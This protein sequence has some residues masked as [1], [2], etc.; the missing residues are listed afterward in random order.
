[1]SRSIIAVATD[2]TALYYFWFLCGGIWIIGGG[3]SAAA[4]RVEAI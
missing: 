3:N 1:M 4:T 2:E